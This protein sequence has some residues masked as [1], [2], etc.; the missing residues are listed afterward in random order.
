MRLPPSNLPA[1]KTKKKRRT[2]PSTNNS[3][4]PLP[5]GPLP[6]RHPKGSRPACHSSPQRTLLRPV[7]GIRSRADKCT[8]V[9]KGVK[10]RPYETSHHR[11]PRP[12][13][14]STVSSTY[15][16]TFTSG[17]RETSFLHPDPPNPTGSWFGPTGFKTPDTG[18]RRTGGRSPVWTVG[19]T[20]RSRGRGVPPTETPYP[21]KSFPP[22]LDRRRDPSSPEDADGV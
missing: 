7:R 19:L 20:T 13:P 16:P 3:P 10:E 4:P 9:A 8:G 5:Q 11:T 17:N 14:C 12:V 22:S 18:T 15:G 6:A 21:T 2:A 1:R